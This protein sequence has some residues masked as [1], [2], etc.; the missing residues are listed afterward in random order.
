[1]GILIGECNNIFLKNGFTYE[2]HNV[3]HNIHNC[4]E[5]CVSLSDTYDAWISINTDSGKGFIYV[6]YECGGE[7]TSYDVEL[8]D[9]L[10]TDAMFEKLDEFA[11]NMLSSY[12]D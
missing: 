3:L 11:T 8:D 2:K 4:Y 10:S 1:M 9:N 6:E 12:I 5:K 7:V